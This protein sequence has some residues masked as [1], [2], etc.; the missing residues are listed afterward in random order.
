MHT[1]VSVCVYITDFYTEL[2][3]GQLT[4]RRKMTVTMH[5]NFSNLLG[6]F[7]GGY[8]CFTMLC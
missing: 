8:S 1:C 5:Q 3:G 2:K 4:F 7:W 6:F